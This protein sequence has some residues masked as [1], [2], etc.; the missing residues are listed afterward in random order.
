MPQQRLREEGQQHD[1]DHQ[2]YRPAQQKI[3]SNPEH[4]ISG[5]R[6]FEPIIQ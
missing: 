4:G 2:Q 5:E 1:Q 3:R 6:L